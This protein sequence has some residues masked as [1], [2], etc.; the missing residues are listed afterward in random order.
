MQLRALHSC[1]SLNHLSTGIVAFRPAARR[2]NSNQVMFAN[3]RRKPSQQLPVILRFKRLSALRKC[4]INRI[5][6]D[7]KSGEVEQMTPQQAT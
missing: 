2:I 5:K 3:S 1:F 7:L 4:P 6:I